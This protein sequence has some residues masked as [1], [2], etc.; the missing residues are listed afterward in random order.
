[1]LRPPTPPSSEHR[2]LGPR[3]VLLTAA[4]A[5]AFPATLV[6]AA[7]PTTA[8]LLALT[9]LPVTRAVRLVTARLRGRT[10][11]RLRVAGLDVSLAVR[12]TRQR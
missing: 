1:M 6:A 8:A 2:S 5:A 3:A 4:L 10:R 12:R 11:F 7:S 9:G